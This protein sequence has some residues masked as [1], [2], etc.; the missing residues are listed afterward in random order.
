MVDCASESTL[1]TI[2]VA[3]NARRSFFKQLFCVLVIITIF[4][5]FISLNTICYF[6]F[7]D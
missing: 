7:V 5:D 1:I 2:F 3:T 4:R 6:H